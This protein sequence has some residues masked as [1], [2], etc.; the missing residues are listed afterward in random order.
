MSAL[1][2]TLLIV[3]NLLILVPAVVIMGYLAVTKLPS[4]PTSEQ[5]AA[6][7]SG[8]ADPAKLRALILRDAEYIRSL[9]ALFVQGS[10]A[11]RALLGGFCVLVVFNLVLLVAPGQK[12]VVGR[13]PNDMMENR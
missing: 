13:K 1:R 6:K 9:E 7:V 5:V 8:M 4:Q 11:V 10:T 2:R 3:L 12:A